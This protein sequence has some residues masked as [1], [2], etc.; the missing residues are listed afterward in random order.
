MQKDYDVI[1]IG[2]AIVDVLAHVEDG[3]LDN[4]SLAKGSMQLV[5]EARAKA[6]YEQVGPTK[7]C[8]G[9]SV[10]NTLA[11][12]AS[13]GATTAFIGKVASDQLGGIFT[14]DM[15]SVGVHFD[16]RPAPSGPATATCLVCV[17]P[18]A[19]R[20]MATFIGACNR[21]SEDDI[22][23]AL[24]AAAQVLYIEGYLWDI[25][26]AKQAI[27]KA[28]ALAKKHGKKVALT[29]SDKFCVDR[30]RDEFLGLISKEVDILFAN[31]SELGALF[32]TSNFDQAARTLQGLCD[33]ALI[34]RSEKGAVFIT[35]DRA[36]QVPGVR[37]DKPVDTTGA[38]DLFAAGFLYGYTRGWQHEASVA[39]GN[40]TA[41]HIIQQLG[42]R[43]M[44]PL[45]RL[46]AA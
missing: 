12:M 32:R 26:T 10:A 16:S 21:V 7:E 41:A 13:L 9:G 39:L 38:G 24:I 46:L 33:V 29:L 25:D 4:N 8:S 5:D 40:R 34:T 17:T 44:E 30:F 6:L 45:E 28:I 27:R 2:N 22:D 31:E 15:K 37:V 1:G 19:Q 11:G 18:D 23:E 36:G 20:T 35:K 3:F 14:H 42:A 43:T